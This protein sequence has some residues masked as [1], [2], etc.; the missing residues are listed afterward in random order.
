V[1][2]PVGN[3]VLLKVKSDVADEVHIHGYDL[4]SAVEAG[5]STDFEFVADASG[6]FEVELE[7]AHLVLV[8]L[9]VGP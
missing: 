5:G 1:K 9:E 2:V 6:I 8:E 7:D 4:V 3:T